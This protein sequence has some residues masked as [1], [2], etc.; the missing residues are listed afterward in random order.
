MAGHIVGDIG[1][2]TSTR[3]MLRTPRK[4]SPATRTGRSSRRAH[5]CDQPAPDDHD[6]R[7]RAERAAEESPVGPG[8]MW[9]SVVESSDTQAG[10]P[11]GE[12]HDRHLV[13]L[14]GQPTARIGQDQR[15]E[16]DRG[17]VHRARPSSLTTGDL[18]VRERR[19]EQ[20]RPDRG[21]QGAGTVG[22]LV[23]PDRQESAVQVG[24][25]GR[26]NSAGRRS[27]AGHHWTLSASAANTACPGA[28]SSLGC[29]PSS[30]HCDTQAVAWGAG[31]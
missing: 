25:P 18:G 21:H 29:G 5:G 24:L 23:A 12:D 1:D 3:L 27:V 17:G 14:G 13:D 26:Q 4:T 8:S 20:G 31:G 15:Q 16:Q 2:S 19:D 7:H 10:R 28:Q 9:N 6:G 30:G 22:R 11:D